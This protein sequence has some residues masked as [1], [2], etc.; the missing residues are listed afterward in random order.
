M[1][2]NNQYH[3]SYCTNIHP[4]EGWRAVFSSLERYVLPIK[5]SLSPQA[6][7]GVGL[8]LS[9]QASRELAQGD[10]LD[11]FR[12]WLD[13][14]DCYVFTMNG[15]PFGGFHS[16]RVKEN[17]HRPDWT[18][19]A[20]VDYT[21]RLLDQLAA[22]LPEQE[23][24]GVSTS[25]ISYKHWHRD[26]T[27]RESALLRGT[28]HLL[29]VVEHLFH[30]ERRTGQH[31][32]L[33]LEPEPDGLLEN[34]VE[35]IAYFNDWLLPMG[36][37]QFAGRLRPADAES[38][39]RR[40]IN[41]C[42]DVCHFAVEYEAPADALRAFR[43][44]GIQIGKVQISAALKA[45]LP[46][47]AEARSK[48]KRQFESL[49]ESTYLHQVI[50][51]HADGHLINYPDLPQALPHLEDA[52]VAEWRTHFH[53]PLFVDHYH[54]LQSTQDDIV[55]VLNILQRDRFT[56]HLEVETYTWE[57]LPKSLQTNLQSSIE[58]E[59]QWVLEVMNSHGSH[60]R[61]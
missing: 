6:P 13:E 9:D 33:D 25:P 14:H 17:V 1:L 50:A 34:T 47:E 59:L 60:E 54:R 51:R 15:F 53:V 29:E 8:R 30:L 35:T 7:F 24:G 4:G 3:L 37:R 32:H 12:S 41:L 16:Q 40:H 18:T 26:Q 23:E 56:R 52:D 21:L 5:R 11:R 2:L 46:A 39:I 57:V 20:R 31:L 58:R 43:E 44:Q 10:N 61:V 27:E 36:I 28:Q 45:L 19:R 55:E 22:L 42:Y 48:I 49:N 38:V